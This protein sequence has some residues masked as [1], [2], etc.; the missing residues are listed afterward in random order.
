MI[1]SVWCNPALLLYLFHRKAL[2]YFKAM[3]I[4]EE[5][6]AKEHDVPNSLHQLNLATV[7]LYSSV[8]IFLVSGSSGMLLLC[9]LQ[10]ELKKCWSPSTEQCSA[11]HP[12]AFVCRVPENRRDGQSVAPMQSALEHCAR[13]CLEGIPG[14]IQVPLHGATASAGG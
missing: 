14:S 3:P 8:C 11:S 4:P 1:S 5:K 6:K 10:S 9:W 7:E 12:V 13:P 2:K